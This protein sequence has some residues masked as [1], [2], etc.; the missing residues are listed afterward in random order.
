MP[1][2][3][4]LLR[5]HAAS[6]P[7]TLLVS[8]LLLLLLLLPTT[9]GALAVNGNPMQDLV[10]NVFRRRG[11][12]PQQDKKGNNN[13]IIMDLDRGLAVLRQLNLTSSTEPRPFYARPQQL[14]SLFT[15]SMVVR[16]L[17]FMLLLFSSFDYRTDS[18][19]IQRRHPCL[20]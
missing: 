19:S 5:A 15:A 4:S 8:L 1:E 18:L 12:Q 17:C 16:Y 2:P 7:W 6:V 9:M 13:D 20:T 3:P 10:K 11:V 14:P